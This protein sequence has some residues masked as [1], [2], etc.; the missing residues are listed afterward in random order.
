MEE[1]KVSSKG[2]IVIPKHLRDELGLE[3][4]RKVIISRVGKE[5]RLVPKPKDPVKAL[6]ELGREL[7]LGDMRK[8]IKEAR[9]EVKRDALLG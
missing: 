3:S 9:K 5:L 8:E 7:K 4:G 2:Q 6:I 1:A